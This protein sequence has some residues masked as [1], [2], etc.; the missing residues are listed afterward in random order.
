MEA[1]IIP[2]VGPI[3]GFNT[4]AGVYREETTLRAGKAFWILMERAMS[5]RICGNA[6]TI[7]STG[8]YAEN[9]G[10]PPP[11]PSLESARPRSVEMLPVYP[12][13]FNSSTCLTLET[14]EKENV[15]VEM[16]AVDG[17]KTGTYFEGD[18][19]AGTNR[20]RIHDGGDLSSGVYLLRAHIGDRT[21]TRKIILTK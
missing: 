6:V 10:T 18:L 21:I 19:P 15:V 2:S 20:I 9:P 7:L 12:N 13:P 4:E 17:R 1:S 8:K 11:P 5:I 3:Y 14:T 16:Y